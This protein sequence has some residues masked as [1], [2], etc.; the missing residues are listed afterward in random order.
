MKEIA[1]LIYLRVG[2]IIFG[3]VKY[4]ISNTTDLNSYRVGFALHYSFPHFPNNRS[5]PSYMQKRYL[6]LIVHDK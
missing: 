1:F 4:V 2:L 5:M 6:H 3:F